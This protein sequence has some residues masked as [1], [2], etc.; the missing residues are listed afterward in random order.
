MELFPDQL[1]QAGINVDTLEK[2]DFF[3]KEQVDLA[4][5]ILDPKIE[6]R[7]QRFE[8][9]EIQ[10]DPFSWAAQRVIEHITSERAAKGRQVVCRSEDGGIRVLTDSQAAPY[11]NKQANAGLQKHKEKTKLMGSAVDMAGLNEHQQ[12]EHDTNR[13]VQ[14]FI[15]SA[16]EK[17]RMTTRDMKKRGVEIPGKPLLEADDA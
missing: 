9:G 5:V 8:R 6:E 3:S 14:Q 12:R 4:I 10:A 13:R 15:Y 17:A 11:L 16:Y 2:G 7:I 1:H